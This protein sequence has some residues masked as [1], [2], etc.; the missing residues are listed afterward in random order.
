MLQNITE[1]NLKDFN[2]DGLVESIVWKF[3]YPQINLPIQ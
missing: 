3:Q 2:T 1:R